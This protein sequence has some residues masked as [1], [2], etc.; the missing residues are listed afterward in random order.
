MNKFLDSTNA[1]FEVSERL[2]IRLSHECNAITSAVFGP[3]FTLRAFADFFGVGW[4]TVTVIDE[5]YAEFATH[6]SR[7]IRKRN[8]RGNIKSTAAEKTVAG[9]KY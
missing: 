6:L 7:K 4:N 1:S 9:K 2:T 5:Q 8:D 3:K